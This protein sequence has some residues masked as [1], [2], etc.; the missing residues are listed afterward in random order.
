MFLNDYIIIIKHYISTNSGSSP[1]TFFSWSIGQN[2]NKSTLLDFFFIG[3]VNSEM[4]IYLERC[5]GEQVLKHF[6][7]TKTGMDLY[8]F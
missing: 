5:F 2:T 1:L 8:E 3:L 4:S 7:F 6:S